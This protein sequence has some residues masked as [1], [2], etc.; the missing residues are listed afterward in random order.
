MALLKNLHDDF[1]LKDLD[2]LHYF[3]GIEVSSS[4]GNFLLT[5]REVQGGLALSMPAKRAGWPRCCWIASSRGRS[6]TPVGVASSHWPC[7]VLE[8]AVRSFFQ[9]AVHVEIG[10]GSNALFWTDRWIHGCSVGHIA[11]CMLAAVP[12][13]LRRH[14]V[15]AVFCNTRDICGALTVQVI[16]DYL[17]LWVLLETMRGFPQGTPNEKN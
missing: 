11:P 17:R 4:Q 9:V 8:R 12:T 3:L 15:S 16:I 13:W 10:N 1:A 2:R 5:R 6:P 7:Q 14:S